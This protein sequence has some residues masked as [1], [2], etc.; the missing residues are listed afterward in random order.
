MKGN[1]P[2]RNEPN[3]YQRWL[4]EESAHPRDKQAHITR[5]FTVVSHLQHDRK[6][7]KPQW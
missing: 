4:T 5:L 3:S 2:Q 7:T 6:H 1:S